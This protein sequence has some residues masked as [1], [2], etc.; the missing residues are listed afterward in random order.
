MRL[1]SLY[2]TPQTS[3]AGRES[4]FQKD[5]PALRGRGWS[6]FCILLLAG[7]L[8]GCNIAK[9]LPA[10]ERLY[11][12]TDIV[13]KADST[14]SA[15][16]QA[17]LTAQLQ[18]LAR[19]KPN[20]KLFGYPY[21]VGLLLPAWVNRRKTACGPGFAKSL[22]E[23]PIFASARAINPPISPSGKQPCKMKGYFDSQVTGATEGERPIQ[24][25]WVYLKS[26]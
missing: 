9:H 22:D 5:S 21:K 6:G 2:A 19:P 10:K 16:E 25:A 18:E 15:G 24:S 14:V 4:K 20:S 11:D 8:T 26:M 23:E 12:G 17:T 3:P 1:V 7:L 13:M